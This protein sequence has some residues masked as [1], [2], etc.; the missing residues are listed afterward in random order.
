MFP[1]YSVISS[2]VWFKVY[3]KFILRMK[4]S[5]SSCKCYNRFNDPISLRSNFLSSNFSTAICMLTA[6]SKPVD[7]VFNIS[8][9]AFVL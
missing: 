2:V 9:W 3:C 7:V 6:R 4:K 5:L 1:K 8:T